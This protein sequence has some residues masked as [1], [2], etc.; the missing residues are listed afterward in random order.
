M[1]EMSTKLDFALLMGKK[2]YLIGEPTVAYLDLINKGNEPIEVIDQLDPSFGVVK[3]YVRSDKE[4]LFRPYII[5]D[6]EAHTVLL[7]PGEKVSGAAKIFFGGKGWT[8][9]KPGKYTIKATYNGIIPAPKTEIKSNNVGV[10]IR[11]PSGKAERAQVNLIKGEEQGLFLLMEGGDHL[12]KGISNLVK[13][14]KQHQESDLAG[15][16]EFALGAN[17]SRNFKDFQ[18]GKVRAAKPQQSVEHLEK[19]MDKEIE[20][21]YM[22]QAYFTLADVYKKYDLGNPNQIMNEF[23]E[24][25]SEDPKLQKSVEK[26]KKIIAQSKSK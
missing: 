18:K 12:K 26:A 13:L 20:D 1:S 11:A 24:N 2:Q 8:F 17:L 25:F 6:A 23:V 3:I 19:T 21:W 5:A 15:Y 16:A 14:A 7:K 9:N 10:H 22:R 4:V